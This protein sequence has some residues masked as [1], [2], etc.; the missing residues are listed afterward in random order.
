MIRDSENILNSRREIP[1][2]QVVILS[3]SSEL[4]HRNI[5]ELR[6]LFESETE[7]GNFRL[8]INLSAVQFIY[9]A[10]I[11]IF[12]TYWKKCTSNN[13]NLLFVGASP[14]IV[15]LFGSLNIGKVIKL[16]DSE[17]EAL[18]DVSK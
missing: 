5:Q 11:A 2:K 6:Q 12:W 4:D 18:E 17:E 14:S 7:A 9:S 10:H 13:G 3:L 15:R 16:Y 1:E 8:I